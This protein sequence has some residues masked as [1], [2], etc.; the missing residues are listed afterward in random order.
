MLV[1]RVKVAGPIFLDDVGRQLLLRGVNLGGDCKV[2]YPDGGTYRPTDFSDHRE[3]SFIGRPF[4]LAEAAE[5]FQRLRHWGFNCIR[6][7]TTWEAIE[8][9]GPSQYDEAYLD[10]FA[11]VC[12]S[13]GEHGFYV[14]VDLHQDVWSRM[15]GGDGAPGWIF[16]AL[17]LD[18]MAFHAAG[19]ALV[20]QHAFDFTNPDPYQP[21]YPPMAWTSNYWLP[22]NGILWTAFWAG[23]HVTPGWTIDGLNVQTLLQ[24]HYLAAMAQVASRV[25]GL[26]NVLGFDTLNEPGVGWLG[27][28]LTYRHLG[29]SP[30]NASLP[31]PGPALSP[32]DGLCMARGQPVRV[33]RLI[34]DPV[35][36][37]TAAVEEACLNAGGVSV[38]K[39]G[40]ECP[41]ERAGIYTLSGGRA[42]PL[43]EEAFAQVENRR[44][45]I[46]ED[47]FSPF[48]QKVAK[49]IRA[50]NPDWAV[51]AEIDPL[52]FHEGRGFPSRLP[53]GTAI[54]GHWYDITTLTT[55]TFNP[56]R[57]V[58]LLTGERADS[59]AVLGRIYERQLRLL[60]AAAQPHGAPV[61]V[62]EFGI[63]FDLEKG[64][65][66]KAWAQGERSPS[67][68]KN[69]VV[70]LDLIYAALDELLLS[71]TQWNYTAT[72]RNDPVIGDG[73]NLE[74]LSIYSADQN[75]DASDP[76]SGGR[77]VEG[78]CR[79]YVRAVQGRLMMMRFDRRTRIF[80]CALLIDPA[81]GAQ[82]EIFVPRVQYPRGI[83]VARRGAPCSVKIDL[84]QQRVDVIAHARGSVQLVIRPRSA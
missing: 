60:K 42:L 61:F 3:V 49:T 34:V 59:T 78:F 41:F 12:R 38:W 44:L 19:A 35:T 10:Y 82:T 45:D 56:A 6:L 30:E 29:P 32:L 77:A 69:H 80:V 54:A 9:A 72:N 7:V 58:D 62:G 4:P 31:R 79:P 63:P 22:V 2:P 65:A 64:A 55:K 25:A 23:R 17:G 81:V 66:Y 73:W 15:S 11:Q 57:H 27:T 46:G 8:H 1:S 47:C 18:F 36:A 14:I 52:A 68:W 67:I 71:G 76:N 33:P 53:P 26:P 24:D 75:T 84:G 5:H 21:T 74:D 83:M 50:W 37:K 43:R 39:P 28:R 13:A 51:F 20:M 48:F 16:D 40:V 70:A